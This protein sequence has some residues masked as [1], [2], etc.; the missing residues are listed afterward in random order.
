MTISGFNMGGDL[1]DCARETDKTKFLASAKKLAAQ[2]NVSE[3]TIMLW[4]YNR[5]D[6]PESLDRIKTWI[7]EEDETGKGLMSLPEYEMAE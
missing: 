4:C 2:R 1:D 7:Q 3:R 6:S 5:A